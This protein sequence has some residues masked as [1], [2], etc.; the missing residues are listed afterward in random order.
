MRTSSALVG[1]QV[2][3]A[4]DITAIFSHEALIAGCKPVGECLS[5]IDVPG[6]CVS[7][8]DAENRLKDAPDGTGVVRACWPYVNNFIV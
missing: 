4:D 3:C 6:K 8:T 1:A 2:I 5:P 7:L